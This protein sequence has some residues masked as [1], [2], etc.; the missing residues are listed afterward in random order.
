MV[1]LPPTILSLAGVGV[2]TAAPALG[3]G[4]FDGRS[5]AHLV[6]PNATA[7]RYDASTDSSDN[8]PGEAAAAA[9]AA[10]AAVAERTSLSSSSEWDRSEKTAFLSHFYIKCIILP[11]QARD[12]HRESTQNKDYRFAQGGVFGRVHG[13]QGRAAH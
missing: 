2:G 6:A 3:V 12:K 11:R 7:L 1:D 5:F 10:A 13:L 9:A 4:A 8:S